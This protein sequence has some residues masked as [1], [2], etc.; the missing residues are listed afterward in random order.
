VHFDGFYVSVYFANFPSEYLHMLRNVD[1]DSLSSREPKIQLCHTRLYNLIN[2][3][4]RTEFI[5][6]FVALLRFVAAG[7]ANIGH[8]RK[9][10]RMIHRI[11]NRGDAAIDKPALRPPQE[12]LNEAEEEI[13]RVF[14]AGEY[15]M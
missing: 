15:T 11:T 14:S 6:E 13:W 4:D 12:D 10:S 1:V 5:K 7:E 8:L 9:D 2:T 3:E